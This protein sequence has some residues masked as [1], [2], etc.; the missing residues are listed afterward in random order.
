MKKIEKFSPSLSPLYVIC[1]EKLYSLLYILKI[2]N[3][4]RNKDIHFIY[5]F[6]KKIKYFFA[7]FDFVCVHRN[8][9]LYFLFFLSS[10]FFASVFVCATN[11]ELK[12]ENKN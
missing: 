6:Y 2:L 11:E 5:F 12:R 3:T 10:I 7:F 9:P 8:L 4:N 1:M